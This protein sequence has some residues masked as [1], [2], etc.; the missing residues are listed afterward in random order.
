M[1]AK[2]VKEIIAKGN[3]V[4]EV[5]QAAMLRDKKEQPKE[6]SQSNKII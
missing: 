3:V 6:P 5:S 1:K 2:R 4:D